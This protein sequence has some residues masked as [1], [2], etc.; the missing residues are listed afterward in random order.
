M[1]MKIRRMTDAALLHSSPEE[2]H[3][4]VPAASTAP[5]HVRLVARAIDT[6]RN[7]A[8]F[9]T[10]Y[11][12]RSICRSSAE[13]YFFIRNMYAAARIREQEHRWMEYRINIVV[14]KS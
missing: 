13:C 1:P 14:I 7:R 6:G 12:R 4:P 2:V 8:L 5:L 11:E 9:V 3:P 10:S